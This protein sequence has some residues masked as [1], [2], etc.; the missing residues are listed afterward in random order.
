M[1]YKGI[2]SSQDYATCPWLAARAWSDIFKLAKEYDTFGFDEHVYQYVKI[3]L[4]RHDKF[5]NDLAM[6]ELIDELHPFD[7][8]DQS[9]HTK[10]RLI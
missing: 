8:T 6:D 3:Q 10:I 2:L 9:T 7:S 4:G 1:F 5:V